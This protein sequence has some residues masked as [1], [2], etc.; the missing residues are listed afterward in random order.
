MSLDHFLFVMHDF[1]VLASYGNVSF[2][3]Q[4]D[5]I[6]PISLT[7][8]VGLGSGGDTEIISGGS[9]GSKAPRRL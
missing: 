3:F 8:T 9:T 5:R 6:S 1:D 7:Y 4:P 2:A